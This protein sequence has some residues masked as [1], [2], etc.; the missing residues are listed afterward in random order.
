MNKYETAISRF[1]C[2]FDLEID[3][4]GKYSISQEIRKG[5]KELLYDIDNLM[6]LDFLIRNGKAKIEVYE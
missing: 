2:D 6:E 5:N 4:K 3:G 1:A